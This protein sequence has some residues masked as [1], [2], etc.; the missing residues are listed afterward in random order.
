[1]KISLLY[2]TADRGINGNNWKLN[3]Y[4]FFREELPK[5]VKFTEYPIVDGM[6]CTGLKNEDAVILWRLTYAELEAM[7]LKG[8]EDL[9]CVKITRAPDAW[10][11]DD[12]YNKKCKELGIDLVV[13]FQS[14]N[15]QYEY[16]DK[17]I[18]YERF[19]L[20]IDDET[21]Q[22]IVPWELR[23]KDKILSSGVLDTRWW[24]YQFR[25]LVTESSFVEYAPKK[26]FLGVDYWLLLNR[27][28]AAIACMSYTSVLKYFEIPMCGGLMF[29]EVTKF[30]QIKEMG[31]ED[32]VNCIY[33]DQ[34]N[35]KQRFKEYIDTVDDPKWERIAGTGQKLV[36]NN[37]TNERE[38][39]RFV[40]LIESVA[41][42]KSRL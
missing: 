25:A 6:D 41:T 7:K 34:L 23:R 12:Y 30:N 31:F 26:E 22:C 24:F 15:C 35:Y 33:I 38:V 16:L 4:R 29:A 10:Q 18:C 19:V 17:D 28:R 42:A 39:K 2:N 5:H 8:F 36:K 40:K 1:M 14:P 32:G 21:Y 9:D 37:Y 13:S 3:N 27:Y 11:I 20:G